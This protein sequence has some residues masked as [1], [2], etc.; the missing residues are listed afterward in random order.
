[1]PILS[2]FIANPN[3][4]NGSLMV[5]TGECCFTLLARGL[6]GL[7]G[8]VGERKGSFLLIGVA[9]DMRRGGVDGGVE[10]LVIILYSEKMKLDS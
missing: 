6:P 2:Q 3:L 10:G 9:C 7:M 1:M 5:R 8:V 4:S